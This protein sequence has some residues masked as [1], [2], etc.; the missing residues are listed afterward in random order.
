MPRSR[1]GSTARLRVVLPCRARSG[2]WRFCR[3]RRRSSVQQLSAADP[4][5]VERFQDG[6]VANV[7]RLLYRSGFDQ[8]A[9]FCFRE[10]ATRQALRLLGSCSVVAGCRRSVVSLREPR[11]N[12]RTAARRAAACLHSSAWLL[13]SLVASLPLCCG[14]RSCRARI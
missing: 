3:S 8:A 4:R 6:A 13:F 14:A 10:H 5:G 12:L 7:A 9:R 1:F 2:A 11:E